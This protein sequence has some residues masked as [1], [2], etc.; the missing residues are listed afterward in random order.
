MK[1]SATMNRF[2]TRKWVF[3]MISLLVS[4][5]SCIAQLTVTKT[6]TAPS[7][8]TVDGCGTYCT[9]LPGVSFAPSDFSLGVCQIADVNVSITWA[10]TDGTCEVPDIGS[11]FHNETNFR[12]DGP[13]ANEILIQPGSYTG[14]G[15]TST[16]T[17]I[18]DQAAASVIGGIDPFSGTFK[19]NNGN[20]DN[21]IGTNPFGTWTL[22]AGDTGGGDPLCIV[23]YSVTITMSAGAD[24]DGDTYTNCN[25]DCN[26]NNASINPG[27][28]E[29]SC[30]GLDNDCN[31]LTV[32]DAIAPAATCQNINVYLDAT[33]FASI[34]GAAVNLS[35]S[36]NCSI[37]SMNVV[38]S[39]FT[40]AN[41]GSLTATLTVTDQI[42]NSSACG[43]IITVFDTLSPIADV[44]S[45]S[46]EVG[47]CSVTSLVAP[48]ATD[49]CGGSVT[50]TNNAVLPIV[51]SGTT[52]V[53]WTYTDA[54]GN[55]STQNQNVL[56]SDAT[57][58]VPD[59]T[60]LTD[61][62]ASCEVASIVAPLATDNCSGSITGVTVTS[63]PI[64]SS[65]TTVVT[66]T[67]T[68]VSGN[69]ST[70]F[71]N[72][73]ISD[74]TAPVPDAV[75]LPDLTASC[76]LTSANAPFATDDCSGTITGV[77]STQFPITTQGTTVI[78][79]SFVDASGNMSSQ[80]QNV[81][82]LDTDAPVADIAALPTVTNA[83]EV[84]LTAPDA[85]DACVGTVSGTTSTSF[86]ITTIGTTLVTWTYNDGNGNS[87]T[88][89]QTVIVTNVNA[90]TTATLD[91]VTLTS[92][93]SGDSYQ[94]INCSGNTPIAGETNA[95][96]TATANGSYAVIVTDGACLDTS[97][98]A[99]VTTV[100]ANTLIIDN[101]KLFP[102][103]T[104]DGHFNLTFDGVIHSITVMD[105]TGREIPV[106]VD[107]QA[108]SVDA[109]SL[110]NGKY[111]VRIDTNNG[112]K[113]AEIIISI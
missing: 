55:S 80:T 68:D 70:Q 109:S 29:I 64:T 40:C 54:N 94:W 103:P 62:S 99:L 72:V 24:I 111:L 66:W 110:S 84:T 46:D 30:D 51:A 102:N 58:P 77:S 14:N 19:P 49:N 38:P 95:N 36:D 71:Q 79:W 15:S 56:I 96:F 16:T 12:I 98:C 60:S 27:A 85:T 83:C 42:G 31:P 61:I 73:L 89:N 20:L 22:R 67:Y 25:G 88:Q 97:A 108:G 43:A 26:D 107:L 13:T 78:T 9:N 91:G 113:I 92:D 3:L 106:D 101:L 11:S 87:S 39:S 76:E 65:G 41:I 7:S 4:S 21:Y 18:L 8:V 50:V 6:Y 33:G 35:S 10:K 86:P 69:I 34:T 74:A 2:S 100:S 93:I 5:A 57:A 1:T 90:T 52:V 45:L 59:A 105:V 23:G 63:F 104:R 112:T 75:S 32:D 47:A 44:P 37:A 82:L 17:T 81:I 28:P 53:T 48:T